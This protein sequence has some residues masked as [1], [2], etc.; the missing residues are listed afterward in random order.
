MIATLRRLVRAFLDL[1]AR[2]SL[3]ERPKRIHK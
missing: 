3:V 1:E 2:T